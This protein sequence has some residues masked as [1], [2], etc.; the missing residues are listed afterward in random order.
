[1]NSLEN[2]WSDHA[3][4]VG[5]RRVI[6]ITL[7]LLLLQAQR[8][9]LIRGR[10]KHS[11]RGS[12]VIWIGNR[13]ACRKC[14]RCAFWRSRS[15][16]VIH[17]EEEVVIII[18]GIL[19]VSMRVGNTSRILFVL[20]LEFL[21]LFFFLLLGDVGGREQLG[22]G[23]A[24]WRAAAVD[25]LRGLLVLGE[26]GRRDVFVDDVHDL[27]VDAA[28]DLV[29]GLERD[30]V[31][32]G[33]AGLELERLRAA[34]EDLGLVLDGGQRWDEGGDEGEDGADEQGGGEPHH[35]VAVEVDEG[36]PE[37]DAAVGRG[38]AK[39]ARVGLGENFAV[40]NVGHVLDGVEAEF[41]RLEDE[42]AGLAEHEEREEDVDGVDDV[43]EDALGLEREATGDEE[44]EEY[45][46]EDHDDANDEDD[47]GRSE[48]AEEEG[49]RDLDGATSGVAEFRRLDDCVA[50]AGLH[51]GTA[52][53][54]S[55][56]QIR[57]SD[58]RL[59]HSGCCCSGTRCCIWRRRC[60]DRRCGCRR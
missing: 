20:F 38:E 48:S 8:T 36:G 51:G 46:D 16:V 3:L 4:G 50:E 5:R 1:M 6:L 24:H 59:I 60:D 25:A 13:F 37:L 31:G 27:V 39:L 19:V 35:R 44:G 43:H 45:L 12:L 23:D 41:V 14:C 29:D 9:L 34:R 15:V 10:R 21:L 47:H 58:R 33:L 52:N 53:G 42:D 28:L 32:H 54:L 30:A 7:D 26:L 40:D 11:N 18:I 57:G 22:L 55:A 49:G 56:L 17:T 2:V